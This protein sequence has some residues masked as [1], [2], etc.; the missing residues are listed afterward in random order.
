MR[1]ALFDD[2]RGATCGDLFPKQH[3]DFIYSYDGQNGR[4]KKISPKCSKNARCFHT[5][6]VMS[7]NETLRDEI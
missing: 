5:L 7:A 6:T 4:E 1:P 3:P 2:A